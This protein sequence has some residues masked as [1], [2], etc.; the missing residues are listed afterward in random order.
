M[1]PEKANQWMTLPM[2]KTFVRRKKLNKS[3]K[4]DI[5]LSM[6]KTNL[7]EGLKKHGFYQTITWIQY[8]EFIDHN[9]N[10]EEGQGDVPHNNIKQ[11]MVNNQNEYELSVYV[12]TAEML[13]SSPNPVARRW[14]YI[15]PFSE[16]WRF[17]AHD[18][19]IV[20]IVP[21]L[22]VNEPSTNN[23]VKIIPY[24]HLCQKKVLFNMKMADYPDKYIEIPNTPYQPPKTKEEQ[25]IEAGLKSHYL[26]QQII[27]LGGMKYPNLEPILDMVQDIKLPEHTEHEKERA[28]IPSGLTNITTID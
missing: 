15:E 4:P 18:D 16:N 26:L 6:N 17:K 20:I 5:L 7:L 11:Y 24:H 8:L 19:Y 1:D 9:A 28:G 27:K 2:L 22:E 25:W 13:E 10:K 12:V 23:S 21:Q 14:F 3:H